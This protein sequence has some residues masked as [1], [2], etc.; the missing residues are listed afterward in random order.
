MAGFKPATLLL[1]SFSRIKKVLAFIGHE[2]LG[3]FILEYIGVIFVFFEVRNELG[4]VPLCHFQVVHKVM[5]AT[6][7]RCAGDFLLL[8]TKEGTYAPFHYCTE[9][10]EE[11]TVRAGKTY[12]AIVSPSFGEVSFGD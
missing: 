6:R 1:C 2:P 12:I 9:D 5:P 4:S 10:G 8:S 7:R 11:L 3:P